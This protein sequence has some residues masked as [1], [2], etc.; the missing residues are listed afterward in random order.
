MDQGQQM[1][2]PINCQECGTEFRRGRGNTSK[3][4]SIECRLLARIEIGPDCWNWT[5]LIDARGYG[6]MRLRYGDA[7]RKAHRLCYEQFVGPIPEGLQLDHL[8]RNRLCV[9]PDHLEPVTNRENTLRGDAPNAV[10][11]RTGICQRG[12]QMETLPNGRR[13]CRKCENEGQMRRY[14]E[15]KGR[16]WIEATR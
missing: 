4:C 3:H 9:N 7:A 15:R 6:Q 12:H 5:G 10:A 14:Y 1:S 13:R 16:A 2:V 8:C 11:H